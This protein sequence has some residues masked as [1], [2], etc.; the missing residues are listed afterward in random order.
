MK[1]SPFCFTNEI[2]DTLVSMKEGDE[3]IPVTLFG[4]LDKTVVFTS[5]TLE[6]KILKQIN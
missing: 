6:V 4:C 2:Q 1:I 5:T 3:A